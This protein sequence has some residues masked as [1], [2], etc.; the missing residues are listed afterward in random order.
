[1]EPQSRF[2]RPD[3]VCMQALALSQ[4][5]I[6]AEGAGSRVLAS[7]ITIAV[8]AVAFSLLWFQVVQPMV[9]E[10]V[11]APEEVVTVIELKTPPQPVP[12]T[13]I[14]PRQTPIERTPVALPARAD[15]IDAPPLSEPVVEAGE[16]SMPTD[17]APGVPTSIEGSVGAITEARADPGVEQL[18]QP[19]YPRSAITRGISGEVLIAIT[20]DRYG[21]PSAVDVRQSSHPT[22]NQAAIKAAWRWTFAPA[23]RNGVP[24]ESVVLVPF[25]FTLSD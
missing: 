21:K 25:Q 3:E 8:H 11:V 20:V 6:E 17:S 14:D 9:A 10:R 12:E 15:V 4:G 5:Q 16:V 18:Y 23:M 19:I 24:V 22:L 2:I 13:R 7:S 1:M